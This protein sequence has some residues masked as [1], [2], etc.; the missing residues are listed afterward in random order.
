MS[1]EWRGF[2]RPL[3]QRSPARHVPVTPVER[4]ITLR[5]GF[6]LALRVWTPGEGTRRR[7]TIVIAHGLGEHA[8]RYAQLAHDLAEVG[9][10]VHAADHRGHGRSIGPRGVIPAQESIRDD[11][12][13]SLVYARS[14]A[15]RPVILLGHSMGG[16][17]AAWAIAHQPKAA[18]ALVLSSPALRADL[19]S[20]QR[21]LIS[22]IGRVHPDMIVTNGLDANYISHDPA[23]VKAYRD[24]PLVHDRVSPRLAQA[25]ITAGDVVRA[26]A[27]TWSTPTLL[28][29][30]GADRLVNP[31]GSLDFAQAAPESIV[32]ALRFDTLYHEIFNEIG[33]EAPLR[34][35][36]DWLTSRAT[37]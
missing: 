30:A 15:M 29:F 31:G 20:I 3:R 27:A 6:R 11:L 17:M 5:D 1:R 37:A 36:L 34:A 4:S 13:E 21:L 14:T 9:W 16:A 18:D 26:A 22:T 28:L 24:D 12:L 32:T 33:R 7:G 10:E 8:G 23:V 2:H 25:I 35:L 19:S